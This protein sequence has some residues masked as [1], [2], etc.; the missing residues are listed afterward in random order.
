[1]D[2]NLNQMDKKGGHYSAVVD[3]TTSAHQHQLILH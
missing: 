3:I 2:L 1:M